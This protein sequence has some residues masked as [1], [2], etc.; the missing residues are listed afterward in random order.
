MPQSTPGLAANDLDA[1][2]TREWLDALSAVIG[3]EGPE[4]AHFLL[5]QLLEH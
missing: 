1:Q 2:E 4:R 3:A 5:E